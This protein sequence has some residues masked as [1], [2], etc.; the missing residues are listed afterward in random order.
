MKS[1]SCFI[2][3]FYILITI[4]GFLHPDVNFSTVMVEREITEEDKPQDYSMKAANTSGLE[5]EKEKILEERAKSPE[6]MLLTMST[7]G[8]GIYILC[9]ILGV[10]IFNCRVWITECCRENRENRIDAEERYRA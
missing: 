1:Y 6:T 8:G 10:L 9:G 4:C 3:C 7:I 5:G 2:I